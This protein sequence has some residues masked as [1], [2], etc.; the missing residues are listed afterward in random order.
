M[1]EI[2]EFVSSS[3]PL[4]AKWMIDSESAYGNLVWRGGK[5]ILTLSIETE[6]Q[7]YQ[8][9]DNP[10]VPILLLTRPGKKVTI[11][12][13][14]GG[15]G[16]VTLEDCVRYNVRTRTNFAQQRTI[17][18]LDFLPS[19]V[20]VGSA[21]ENFNDCVIGVTA[22][23]ARLVGF[24]GSPELKTYRPYDD[25][26]KHIFEMLGHPESVW[27]I[28]SPDKAEILIGKTDFTLEVSSG[29]SE[30]LSS[31]IGN[32]LKSVTNV[33]IK[34]TRLT[35]I[36]ELSNV[37]FKFEEMLSSFSLE[38]FSFESKT[39]YSDKHEK[40]TRV[41]QLGDRQDLFNAPMRHQILIDLSDI[42]VL[43]TIC[44]K[45][46]SPT[47]NV[48][49]SRWL[50]VR[51]LKETENGLARFVTVVQAFEVLGRDFGRSEKIPKEQLNSAVELVRE[52]LNGKVDDGFVNRIIQLIRSSNRS[53]FR[54]TME[55]MLNDLKDYFSLG[56]Q[57][58][59]KNF[60]KIVSDTRNAVIHMNNDD[61][62]VL[63]N[64]FA[65]INKLSMELCFWYAVLQAHHLGLPINNI[66]T[67]LYNNRN[68]RHG[69]PNEVLERAR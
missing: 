7:S 10:N 33:N 5:P 60:C 52:V 22:S 51:S 15:Y 23:D 4:M 38:V 40:I 37:V 19:S 50:F 20:W 2:S 3:K 49:L 9:D 45:W 62:D 48:E 63:N 12:G 61:K 30:S 8:N 25:K 64:A 53:S 17:F 1:N 16:V 13:V 47:K 29:V 46:F 57:Y 55:Y 36:S 56:S 14:V 35:T 68:A 39:F 59:L 24:F 27:T 54:E 44:K 65:R 11:S 66:G 26:A 31:T 6:D 41:W 34:S 28:H 21:K 43:Q 69:L 42:Y 67:F 58:D 18:E 32:S